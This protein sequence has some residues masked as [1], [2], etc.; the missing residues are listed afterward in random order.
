MS[1]GH[2]HQEQHHGMEE[3]G[4]EGGDCSELASVILKEVFLQS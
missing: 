4:G 2:L 3:R 1:P